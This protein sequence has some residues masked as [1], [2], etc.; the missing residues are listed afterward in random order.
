EGD[1]RTR[2]ESLI[3]LASRAAV[4]WT[5]CGKWLMQLVGRRARSDR[6]WRRHDTRGK[7]RRSPQHLPIVPSNGPAPPHFCAPSTSSTTKT[8]N[9]YT[10]IWDLVKIFKPIREK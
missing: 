1:F 7:P 6:P 3:S 8:S 10:T 2:L 4:R 5:G 9:A